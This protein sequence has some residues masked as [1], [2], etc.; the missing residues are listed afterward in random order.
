MFSETGMG[1]VSCVVDESE[2]AYVSPGTQLTLYS[3]LRLMRLTVSERTDQAPQPTP[4]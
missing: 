3:Q 1:L 2:P 4:D